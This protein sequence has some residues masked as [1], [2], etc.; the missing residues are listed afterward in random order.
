[1]EMATKLHYLVTDIKR[2]FR[3]FQFL[4]SVEQI[5]TENLN[6]PGYLRLVDP[7]FHKPKGLDLSLGIKLFYDV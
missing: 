1:M 6:I 4:K 3:V 7:E 5:P 2:G